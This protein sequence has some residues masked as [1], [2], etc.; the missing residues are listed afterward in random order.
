MNK[1][2]IDNQKLSV[3]ELKTV[4]GGN[5]NHMQAITFYVG[6]Y[7]AVKGSNI[8]VGDYFTSDEYQGSGTI[9]VYR[10]ESKANKTDSVGIATKFSSY[11]NMFPNYTVETN[12]QVCLAGMARI[13]K[14]NWIKE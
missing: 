12:V 1:K 9:E 5:S 11:K 3:K 4:T 6:K 7:G 10:L 2:E 8:Q 13:Y 14:P